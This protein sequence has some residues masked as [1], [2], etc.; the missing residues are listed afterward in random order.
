MLCSAAVVSECRSPPATLRPSLEC[1]LHAE[2]LTTWNKGGG[3]RTGEKEG[4]EGGKKE[5]GG[6]DEGGK[7]KRGERE[8]ELTGVQ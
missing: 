8:R 7:Q 1:S 3:R 5:G 6:R 2:W 4:R